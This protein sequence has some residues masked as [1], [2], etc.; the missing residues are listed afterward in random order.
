MK[1]TPEERLKARHESHRRWRQKNVEFLR[2]KRAKYYAENKVKERQKAKEWQTNNPMNVAINN[3][4]SKLRFVIKNPEY[5][6]N[7]RKNNAEKFTS[8]IRLRQ[9]R[10][11][12]GGGN[13]SEKYV[14]FLVEAQNGKC[15]TCSNLFK[16]SG[17]EI[18]HIIPLVKGGLH[19]DT[20]IQ[21]LCPMCNQKKGSRSL[22]VF[23]KILESQSAE[24]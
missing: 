8:S 3:R 22:P 15:M 6:K 10:I 19:C 17:Y 2:I 11:R 21:L 4:I 20:N 12:A 9:A 1:M 16:N 14:C 24:R 7:Y 18:D 5:F 13:V 23:M